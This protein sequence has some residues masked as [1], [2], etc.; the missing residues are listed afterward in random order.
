MNRQI[1][2]PHFLRTAIIVFLIVIAAGCNAV[3]PTPAEPT[4]APA[5]ETPAPT[6]TATPVPDK[7]LF[8]ALPSGGAAAGEAA[9]TVV[10]GLAADNQLLFEA[11]PGLSAGDLKPEH[12]VVV[13]SGIPDNLAELLTAAPQTQFL[14][15]GAGELPA[16]ANLSVV[17][18]SPEE[19]LFISG[20]LATILAG[21]RR[22][23]GVLT[24]DG[25]VGARAEEVFI[26]GGNYFCGTCSPQYAP[27]VRFPLT[28]ALPAASDLTAWQGAVDALHANVVY[29]YYVTPEAASLDLL[30][31][32]GQK[33]VA[34]IGGQTP[35]DEVRGV[36]AATVRI[37]PLPALREMFPALAQGQGGQQVGASLEITDVNNQILSPGR[38]ELAE[39]VYADLGAGLIN[40]FDPPLQ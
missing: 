7:A 28:A 25:P 40:P 38:K 18:Y 17:R 21:D 37:D 5:T 10:E 30:S 9:R 36:W 33:Q 39:R 11:L 31:Y 19:Q 8:V 26:N 20:F 2:R 29:V 6:P 34:L 3:S 16:A 1:L 27:F 23:A 15:I 35:P 24:N 4:Q 13:F 22:A 14:V 12:R 32:V